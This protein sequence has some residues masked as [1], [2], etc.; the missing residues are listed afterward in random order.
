MGWCS[1]VS[2]RYVLKTESTPNIPFYTE[3][4]YI[5]LRRVPVGFSSLFRIF[6]CYACLSFLNISSSIL[7]KSDRSK[8]SLQKRMHR[9]SSTIR[10]ACQFPRCRHP[11]CY[12]YSISPSIVCRYFS[13][14]IRKYLLGMCEL[15]TR[16]ISY[17][18]TF[19]S[20]S[21]EGVQ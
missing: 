5:A 4:V 7:F 13:S 3:R 18:S 6:N 14:Y 12:I 8:F 15:S 19:I 2:R 21:L 17:R 9:K 20:S 11:D 10:R 1:I 16:L